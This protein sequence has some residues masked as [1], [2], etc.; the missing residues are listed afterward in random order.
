MFRLL[1]SAVLAGEVYSIPVTLLKASR[2]RIVLR[3]GMKV[4]GYPGYEI[5][6]A[7]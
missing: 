3:I 2:D 5:V 7:V 6:I 4:F 1:D